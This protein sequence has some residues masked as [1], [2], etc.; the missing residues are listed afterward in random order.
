MILAHGDGSEVNKASR[1]DVAVVGPKHNSLVL[2]TETRI[3]VVMQTSRTGL[4]FAGTNGLRD[5][6]NNVAPQDFII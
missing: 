6:R 4:S 5:G 3:F 1:N 2:T